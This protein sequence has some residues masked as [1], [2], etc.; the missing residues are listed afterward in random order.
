MRKNREELIRATDLE[1]ATIDHVLQVLRAEFED[2]ELPLEDEH[3][4]E[5]PAPSY[6]DDAEVEG[7]SDVAA[8][9]NSDPKEE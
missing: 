4:A 3:S 2:E 9:L 6:D 7:S 5:E 8:P 1:E